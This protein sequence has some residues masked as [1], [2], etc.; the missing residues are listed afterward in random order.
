[1]DAQ[2]LA[3]EM[4]PVIIW[5]EGRKPGFCKEDWSYSPKDNSNKYPD[6]PT[7]AW[8]FLSG[9][10]FNIMCFVCMSCD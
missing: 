8:D 5:Q 3:M 4:A 7:T 6:L 2:T 1:M 9:K 10:M